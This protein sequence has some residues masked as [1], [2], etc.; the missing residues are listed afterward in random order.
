MEGMLHDGG[1]NWNDCCLTVWQELA[2]LYVF[3]HVTCS[4]LPPTGATISCTTRL[5]S[6]SVSNGLLT[7]NSHDDQRPTIDVPPLSLHCKYSNAVKRPPPGDINLRTA[8]DEP[9]E[10]AKVGQRHSPSY[11]T[12]LLFIPHPDE[13]DY[14]TKLC[15]AT[16]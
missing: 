14:V 1:A 13:Q 2:L 10:I 9:T 5:A 15:P 8:A 12:T 16:R 3:Y 4:A 6:A 7:N 11:T